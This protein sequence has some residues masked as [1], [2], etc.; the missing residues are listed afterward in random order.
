MPWE[1]VLTDKEA[2]A[3][4]R[5]ILR[6]GAKIDRSSGGDSNVEGL[7]EQGLLFAYLASYEP[8]IIESSRLEETLM[9]AAGR[10]GELASPALFGGVAGVAWILEHLVDTDNFV[11]NAAGDPLDSV[12]ELLLA[13]ARS[14]NKKG[15]Y[16]LISGTVGV[17]VYFLERLGSGVRVAALSALLERLEQ[18]AEV[19]GQG[20]T[21]LTAA[22]L[23]TPYARSQYPFGRYDLGVAHGIAGVIGFLGI[24]AALE[25]EPARS[26][27]LLDGCVRWL[28]SQEQ[29]GYSQSQFPYWVSHPD[30][31][32]RSRIAWCYGDLGI[33]TI[34]WQTA[35]L[36]GNSEW[37]EYAEALIDRCIARGPDGVVDA[38]LCH[39]A[40]GVAHMFNRLYQQSAQVKH[41]EA[42]R[43]YYALT[44]Q[45]LEEG[46]GLPENTQQR[47]IDGEI[48]IALGLMAASHT[49]EPNWDR[50]M[51]L[52]CTLDQGRSG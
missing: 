39:G 36:L 25:I 33:G 3:A 19:D 28:I 7:A 43:N 23:L 30:Q 8:P 14:S 50:R 42:A 52:S 18:T 20:I 44:I 24:L 2:V 34:L 9:V 35:R 15:G 26:R 51:L 27:K 41:K 38:G 13:F 49:I 6:L 45:L 21:W 32:Q 16:D 37:L 48:G 40:T 12:D 10:I 29:P 5:I 17:G 11:G 22:S 46:G 4:D 1:R 31:V 47:F